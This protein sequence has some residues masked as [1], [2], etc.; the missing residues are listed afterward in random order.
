MTILVDGLIDRTGFASYVQQEA[1]TDR[2]T[3]V[4]D[5]LGLRG[6]VCRSYLVAGDIASG[7]ERAELSL[8]PEDS[9]STSL[10]WYSFATLLQSDVWAGYAGNPVT[11]WQSHD[12]PDGG[13]PARRPPLELYVGAGGYWG[14]RIAGGDEPA[15]P[16]YLDV[17]PLGQRLYP[18]DVWVD[19]TI[20]VQYGFD[21][22]G[23][24]TLWKDSRKYFTLINKAIG[25]DD[26]S[27]NASK[28]GLYCPLGLQVGTSALAFHSG[29]VVGDN[30]YATFDAFMAAAGSSA[31]ELE[32][33]V[34]RG[35]SL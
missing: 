6:N 14:F 19:W 35:M 20:L 26:V 3:I 33:F 10:R 5:P 30:A 7:S 9:P 29:I 12:R 18:L 13:D 23:D 2:L 21:G 8:T 27:G 25:Y 4:S 15:A 28:C 34:T 22:T 1:E 32:G 16:T 11:I 17:V 24:I 31:V